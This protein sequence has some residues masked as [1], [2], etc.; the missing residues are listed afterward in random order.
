M[1]ES[2]R[3][4]KNRLQRIARLRRIRTGILLNRERNAPATKE[5]ITLNCIIN[6]NSGCWEWMRNNDKDGYGKVRHLGKTQ[7]VHRVAW[8]LWKGKIPKGMCVLHSCDNPPCCNPDHLFIGT[9]LDNRL[10]CAAKERDDYKL[11]KSQVIEILHTTG[12]L[13]KVGEMFGVSE[14]VVHRIR[15]GTHTRC[16]NLS[17]AV[18]TA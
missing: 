7:R 4:R 14:V 8:M 9:M 2:K 18:D 1:E 12:T 16:P 13:K 3:E 11:S 5:F 15:N 6:P 10:D 17:T